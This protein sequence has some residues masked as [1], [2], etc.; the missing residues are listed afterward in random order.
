LT[1]KAGSG[2]DT[3]ANLLGYETYA[4]AKP[5]KA[6]L[7]VMGFPEPPRDK[8]EQQISGFKFSW[9]KAAQLLGTEW[10]RQLQTDL[11]LTMAEVHRK[12]S[13]A[14]CLVITDVRFHNEADWIRDHGV[15]LHVRGRNYEMN[16]GEAQH[17]SELELPVVAGDIIIDNSKDI[18]HLRDQIGAFLWAR[19]AKV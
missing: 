14:A 2:K 18:L 3:A 11:W 13:R 8:K 12:Q 6:A 9:R 15:L 1:G 4:F 16:P 19:N 17:A 5:L 10:G 7:A